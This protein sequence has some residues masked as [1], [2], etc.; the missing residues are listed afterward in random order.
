MAND[1]GNYNETYFAQEAMMSLYDQ[2]GLAR[3]VFMGYDTEYSTHK[4]GKTIEIRG[5]GS[6]IATNAPGS[7]QDIRPRDTEITL[8]QHKDVV[9]AIDDKDFALT[10]KQIITEH[11]EPA[12]AAL[13][14]PVDDYIGAS[15]YEIPWQYHQSA[16]RYND[17]TEIRR[18]M[19]LAKVPL[20]QR[21]L[22]NWMMSTNH[23]KD[24]LQTDNFAQW[25]GGGQTVI[26][27]IQ[28][29]EL[30]S[31]LGYNFWA[32]QNEITHTS[33]ATADMVGA[34]DNGPGYAKGIKVMLVKDLEAVG[35]FKKG[36]TFSITQ[37]GA[38]VQRYALTADTTMIAGGGTINFVPGL[39]AA[40]ADS[41]T[42]AFTAG[43]TA[44]KK[45]TGVCSLAF[46]R[47]WYALAFGRLPDKLPNGVPIT[48]GV[49]T[50]RDPITG[51]SVRAAMWWEGKEKKAY[52]S[53]DI[54][55]GG[56][57][58]DGNLAARL[59]ESEV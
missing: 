3:A 11:I 32:N 50:V 59:H 57:V 7:A 52:V 16:D 24:L 46:H 12:A 38:P 42:L 4:K 13:A 23:E 41:D 26:P 20:R 1:M 44:T 47:N 37:A 18:L 45:P 48:A 27:T 30:G 34:V 22:M 21:Q 39:A 35:V 29:G 36:D 8:D 5:P 49:T 43:Q 2:L 58:L 33:S 31:R 19:R 51:L 6:F 9:F 17:V 28:T 10:N 53:L 55:Y 14:L 56:T 54:L 25:S 15:Y 40:V